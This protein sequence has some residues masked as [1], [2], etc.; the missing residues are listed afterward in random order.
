MTYYPPPPARR[1]FNTILPVSTNFQGETRLL[2]DNQYLTAESAIRHLRTYTVWGEREGL[3]DTYELNSSC[4]GGEWFGAEETDHGRPQ[5]AV[6]GAGSGRGA[7]QL[8]PSVLALP[9]TQHH[10]MHL[11]ARVRADPTQYWHQKSAAGTEHR[12]RHQIQPQTT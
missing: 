12:Q 10:L 8:Q 2:R 5:L 7:D 4:G 1:G 11:T 3:F 9:G 6:V